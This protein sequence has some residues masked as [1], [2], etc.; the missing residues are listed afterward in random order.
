MSPLCVMLPNIPTD[1]ADGKMQ[2]LAQRWLTAWR[3]RKFFGIDMPEEVTMTLQDRA[4][5]S[6]IWYTP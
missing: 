5:T 6:P 2:I 4:Y 1:A 3:C